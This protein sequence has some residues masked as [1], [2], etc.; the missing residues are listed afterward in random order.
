MTKHFIVPYILTCAAAL[1]PAACS[2]EQPQPEPVEDE[3]DD[4]DG[5][6]DGVTKPVGTYKPSGTN[7]GY[8]TLLV[9]ETNKVFHAEKQVKCVTTPC[10]P[11]HWTGTY[12]LT[13]STTSGK[14]FLRFDEGGDVSRYEYKLDAAGML[15]VRPEGGGGWEQLKHPEV[16]WCDNAAACKLQSLPQ[17]KCPGNWQCKD[18]GCSF[19]ECIGN[20]ACEAA[21][22][23]CEALG[24]E[25]CKL[26]FV[27]D[28]TNF[29]CG[30]ALG[31]QCCL[32]A[33]EAPVCKFAGT[34]QEGWYSAGGTKI[35]AAN[36]G[37]AAATCGALGTKSEGWYAPSGEGCGGGTLVAWDKCDL[38][39]QCGYLDTEIFLVTCGS[40]SLFLRRWTANATSATCAEY[41]TLDGDQ[42]SSKQLALASKTCDTKC[43]RAPST[44]V[45]LMRCGIKTGYIKYSA[46]GCGDLIDTPD[47]IFK[48]VEEWNAKAPC[49]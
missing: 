8:F 9:L 6:A 32:P 35:C 30:G 43:L 3:I 31:V 13:K 49:L 44:S 38:A 12:K 7:P 41:W 36:C 33:P 40:K 21:G 10:K 24:P 2:S 26:G 47:G 39:L 22:G 45:S 18:S 1:F 16:A 34:S 25:S 11:I 14:K 37:G 17:P 15:S 5:K 20:N 4:L 19:S 46:A 29:S 23:S 28:A 42:F 48:S 27:G